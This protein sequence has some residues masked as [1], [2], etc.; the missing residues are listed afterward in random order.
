MVKKISYV[1]FKMLTCNSGWVCNQ[2]C[3]NN[4]YIR[5]A[6]RSNWVYPVDKGFE[7][8]QTNLVVLRLWAIQ[9]NFENVHSRLVHQDNRV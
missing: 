9:H 7:Y 1:C 2:I 6:F 4:V 3:H 8:L 5:F